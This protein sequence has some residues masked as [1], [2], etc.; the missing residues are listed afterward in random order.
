MATWPDLVESEGMNPEHHNE[1]AATVR[2]PEPV[3]SAARLRAGPAAPHELDT[4]PFALTHVG[5]TIDELARAVL[6]LGERVA[7][8][9]AT[10]LDHLSPEARAL[11]WH[12]QELESLVA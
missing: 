9:S 1:L 5:D 2:A 12:L 3:A 10:D 7:G 4:L 6:S 8:S 11:C